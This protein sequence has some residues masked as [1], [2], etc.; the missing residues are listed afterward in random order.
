MTK[1][2]GYFRWYN[3]FSDSTKTLSLCS[4]LD[5]EEKELFDVDL[6]KVDP[7]LNAQIFMY[8]VGK[9][10]C[11]LDILPPNDQLRQ[12]LKLNSIDYNHDIKFALRSTKNM[13]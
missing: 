6:R 12:I 5:E 11:G 13:K 2:L 9:Y 4:H 10:Y 8:G 1:T 3:S 7:E